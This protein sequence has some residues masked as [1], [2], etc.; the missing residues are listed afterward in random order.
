MKDF[1][2]S[3]KHGTRFHKE[4]YFKFTLIIIDVVRTYNVTPVDFRVT[5]I[6]NGFDLTTTS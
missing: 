2:P 3:T 6:A 1:H 5:S 4:P